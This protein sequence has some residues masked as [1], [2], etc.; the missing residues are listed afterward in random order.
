MTDNTTLAARLTAAMEQAGLSQSDLAR[1]SGTTQPTINK[2]LN[3]SSKHSKKIVPIAQALGVAVEWLS[4]GNGDRAPHP[5]HGATIQ[6][7]NVPDVKTSLFRIALAVERI[8]N[9][10]ER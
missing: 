8:A 1:L 2:I 6:A 7:V 3:G 5:H 9:S 4:T 10:L